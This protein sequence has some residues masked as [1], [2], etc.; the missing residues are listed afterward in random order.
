MT[1]YRKP[2]PK[3]QKEISKSLQQPYTDGEGRFIGQN[4]NF[5]SNPNEFESG[6][7]FNR[8]EKVSQKNDIQKV[9]TITIQD[10]D[11]AIMYYFTEVIK[12]SVMQNERR[13][14]VPIIY[15]APERWKSVKKMGFLG[16][17]KV[18]LCIL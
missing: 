14:N 3:T 11:E 4:P 15:G 9:Q 13:I 1:Q 5:S 18:Q 17:K 10:V 12:P 6:V 2:I 8:A 16:I 7:N